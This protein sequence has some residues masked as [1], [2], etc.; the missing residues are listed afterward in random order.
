[1][2]NYVGQEYVRFTWH[3][4]SRKLHKRRCKEDISKTQTELVSG[5]A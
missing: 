5:S 3:C 2:N 4:H 1:M